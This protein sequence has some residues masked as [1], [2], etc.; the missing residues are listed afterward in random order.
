VISILL[1]LTAIALEITAIARAGERRLLRR[2]KLFYLYLSIVLLQDLSLLCVYFLWP[3]FY[4]G[5][6]W[7]SELLGV[8]AGCALVW[9]V[10]KLALRRYPGAL[11][12]AHSLLLFVFIITF[13]RIVVQVW[14]SSS[15]TPGA[16]TLQTE[17]DLRVVQAAMLLGLIG[18][19][20]YYSIPLGRNLKGIA[21]GY[22]FFLLTSVI[23]LQLRDSLGETFQ[24]LWQYIQPACYLAVLGIWCYAL[25]SYAPVP[26]ESEPRLEEHYQAL[27]ARAREGLSSARARILRGIH[28]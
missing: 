3:R 17:L 10:Y 2:Y 21:Y 6:Y 16:T 22:G 15:W 27:R 24:R 19:F 20:A 4:R 5:T 8:A 12:V 23:N 7:G 9:E 18:L 11:R 28:P 14:D 1:W 25:W 26:E 13:T